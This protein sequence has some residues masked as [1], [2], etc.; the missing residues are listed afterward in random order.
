MQAQSVHET[1][2]SQLS[3]LFCNNCLGLEDAVQ[4]EMLKTL[5]FYPLQKLPRFL[6]FDALQ[7]LALIYSMPRTFCGTS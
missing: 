4:S 1:A 5:L 6:P 7:C 2:P 3:T